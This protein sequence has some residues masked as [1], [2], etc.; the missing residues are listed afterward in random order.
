MLLGNTSPLQVE[1]SGIFDCLIFK[2]MYP[3]LL[4]LIRNNPL[5]LS[6]PFFILLLIEKN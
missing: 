5:K 1:N 4:F 2:N 3:K 6:L